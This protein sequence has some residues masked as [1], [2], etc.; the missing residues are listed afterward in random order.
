MKL[1]VVGVDRSSCLQFLGERKLR[2]PATSD[3]D[4]HMV[5]VT[6]TFVSIFIAVHVGQKRKESLKRD[7]RCIEVRDGRGHSVVC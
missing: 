5:L 6:R 3:R 1:W 7:D 2:V 4:T